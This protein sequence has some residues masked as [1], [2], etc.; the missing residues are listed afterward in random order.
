MGYRTNRQLVSYASL[1]GGI[2]VGILIST[3]DCVFAG[4][5]PIPLIAAYPFLQFVLPGF[6]LGRKATS[7]AAG[8]LLF[9]GLLVS[10]FGAVKANVAALLVPFLLFVLNLCEPTE[11]SGWYGW[12]V[13][14]LSFPLNWIAGVTAIATA[15]W[16]RAKKLRAAHGRV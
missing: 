4:D 8:D 14:G 10:V 1:I 11:V 13:L 7:R 12:T 3:A 6:I 5:I 9:E 2:T 16:F 15:R